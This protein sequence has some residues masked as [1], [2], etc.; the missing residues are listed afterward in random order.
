MSP[1]HPLAAVTTALRQRA[2]LSETAHRPWPLPS[3]SWFM[4]QSWIDLLFAHWAVDAARLERVVPPQLPLDRFDGQVWLG[5]TP[6]KVEGVRLRNTPPAPVVSRFEEINVRTY[7]TVD[8]KPGIYFLSLDAASR[9]AVAS[10][11]RTYRLPYF[12]AAMQM[13]RDA[14]GVR[15]R[16]RRVS[17]DGHEAGIVCRYRPAG[18]VFQAQPG[19]LEHF[20]TERYCL[21]TLDESGSIQRADIHHPP[22]PLQEAGAELEANAMASPFGVE[23]DGAPLAHFAA[24]QDVVLWSIA[25]S[26]DAG[27]PG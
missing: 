27:S 11:R 4:G 5:V 12:R 25:P 16:S 20:L 18:E 14:R 21:Y 26:R 19:T 10:A 23:L 24:R 8:G 9:A 6:F 1:L 13:E 17:A 3:S 15:F 7:V 2:T 22:W